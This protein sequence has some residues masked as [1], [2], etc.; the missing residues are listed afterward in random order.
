MAPTVREATFD[1][2]RAHGMTTI[3]GNPGSTELPMLADFPA[4]FTLRARAPGA[5]G[6][7][8]GRRLRAGVA[9]RP[10]TSTSTPPPASATRS[11]GSSTRRRTSRRW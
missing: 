3:F 10:R 5:G 11:V 4:D 7:R 1:L 8:D 9:A 2:F 6:G